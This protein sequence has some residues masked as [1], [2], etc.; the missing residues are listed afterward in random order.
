VEID[1]AKGHEDK[2]G[3][4]EFMIAPLSQMGV[5]EI[6]VIEYMHPYLVVA[7]HMDAQFLQLELVFLRKH[8]IRECKVIPRLNIMSIC[9]VSG[10]CSRTTFKR[11]AISRMKA[12]CSLAFRDTAGGPSPRHKI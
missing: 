10:F 9:R 4:I 2:C 11:C 6:A 3:F 12:S 5:S 1:V 7:E 8:W